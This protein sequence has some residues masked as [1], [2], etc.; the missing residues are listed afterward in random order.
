MNRNMHSFI[1]TNPEV[2][3]RL[4]HPE[5]EWLTG[6]VGLSQS[7]IMSLAKRGIIHRVRKGDNKAWIWRTDRE[8]H[9]Y[10]QKIDTGGGTPDPRFV[11]SP[12]IA[13]KC[14]ECG[15]FGFHNPESEVGLRCIDCEAVSSKDAW[16]DG[17]DA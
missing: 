5:G 8:A 1:R 10:I 15:Y 11:D 12:T 6:N 7:E 17:G 14:P 3:E 2:I 16:R 13:P 4:P 9:R